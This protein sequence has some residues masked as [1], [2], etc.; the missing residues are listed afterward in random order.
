[1]GIRAREVS[2]KLAEATDALNESLRKTEAAF[3]ERLGPETRGRTILRKNEDGWIE[4]LLF[5]DGRFFFESGWP[6][7]KLNMVPLLNASREVRVKAVDCLGRLWS[8]CGG[9]PLSKVG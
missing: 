3:V 9:A 6:G 1:M 8:A 4:H 5:R 7:E 2:R